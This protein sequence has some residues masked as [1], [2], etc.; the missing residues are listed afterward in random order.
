MGFAHG[1]NHVSYRGALNPPLFRMGMEI[2]KTPH[3]AA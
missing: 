3:D 1:H 2:C